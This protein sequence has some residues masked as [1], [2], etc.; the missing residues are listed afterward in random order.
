MGLSGKLWDFE[1]IDLDKYPALA[2]WSVN[3]AWGRD[4]LPSGNLT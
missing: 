4:V 3:F 1:D 2:S